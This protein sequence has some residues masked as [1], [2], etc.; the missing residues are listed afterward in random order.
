MRGVVGVVA[1]LILSQPA[2]AQE[3]VTPLDVAPAAAP[4]E[5]LPDWMS[6]K[7]PYSGEQN[8]IRKAHR[9]QEEILAWTQDNIT[10]ALS[11]PA[12][13]A[14]AKLA[15]VQKIFTPAALTQ[16]KTY[17]SSGAVGEGLRLQTHDLSTIVN[18]DARILEHGETAGSYRWQ[19][20]LPLVHSFNKIEADGSVRQSPGRSQRLIVVVG[21]HAKVAGSQA[22]DANV[23]IES[24]VIAAAAPPAV[25]PLPTAP[26]AR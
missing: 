18:G 1:L 5:P 14:A 24:F 25:A 26:A 8:D 17:L 19:I 3:G 10:N 7:A 16:Y 11:V 21:R 22:D 20:D 4:A 6:Y 12:G 13:G 15:E 9:S 23:R 2:V